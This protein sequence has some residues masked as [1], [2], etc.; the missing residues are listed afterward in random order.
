MEYERTEDGQIQA[1]FA[2]R[3]GK[4]LLQYESG[5]RHLAQAD[6][7]EG[8]LL[9]CLLQ[10]VL[11]QCTE[12]M[13]RKGGTLRAALDDVLNVKLKDQPPRFGFDET[14]IAVWGHSIGPPT[15]RELI[16]VVRNA[17]SHP[18]VQADAGYPTTGY[19]TVMNDTELIQNFRFVASPWVTSAEKQKGYAQK[20]CEAAMERAQAL[21]EAS[22]RSKLGWRERPGCYF[23][24]LAGQPFVPHTIVTLSVLQ[25]RTLTLELSDLLGAGTGSQAAGVNGREG[26]QANALSE[27]AI[28]HGAPDG[29][30]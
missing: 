4:V 9:I 21:L 24:E 18:T 15:Y 3:V 10:A 23:L 29:R 17:L 2:R 25:L 28:K 14:C 5:S 22:Q 30:R 27:S 20:A 11:N 6:Q 19:T 7:H 8:T 13:R 26:R 12:A 16:E 1:A